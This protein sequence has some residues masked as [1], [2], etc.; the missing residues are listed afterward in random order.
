MDS[1]QTTAGNWTLSDAIK[2]G[3]RAVSTHWKPFL[4]IQVVALLC[5][6]AYY[7]SEGFSRIAGVLQDWKVAGGLAFAFAAGAI[8]G[9]FVPELARMATNSVEGQG[10]ERW[11]KVLWTSLV[12]GLVGVFVDLFYKGQ[13]L[14]FG[15]G[16]DPLTLSYKT[17]FDMFIFA[18]LFCIP[19]EVASLQ[20]PQKGYQPIE[21]VKGFS[22]ATFR[23]SVLPVLIP[24]WAF[25]IPVLLCVYAMPQNLQFVFAILAEAAWSIIVVCVA[26]GSVAAEDDSDV[27]GEDAPQLIL[28]PAE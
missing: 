8:A 3:I 24:C 9:G 1:A 17:A 25:W 6:V 12:F 18:P 22:W 11:H 23:D 21:F 26:T 19:F 14:I 16:I 13:A 28:E 15:N 27:S 2:P 10:W 20:W 4:L 7:Q 5:V